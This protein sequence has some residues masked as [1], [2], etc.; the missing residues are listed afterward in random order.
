MNN[1]KFVKPKNVPTFNNLVNKIIQCKHQQND[2]HNASYN[3]YTYI[4]HITIQPIIIIVF[5]LFCPRLFIVDKTC[6]AIIEYIL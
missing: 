1:R 2:K 3:M 5:S 4:T 6:K